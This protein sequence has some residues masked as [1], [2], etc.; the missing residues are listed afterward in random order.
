M[1]IIVKTGYLSHKGKMYGP[2]EVATVEEKDIVNELLKS[3]AFEEYKVEDVVEDTEEDTEETVDDTE[4]A[5]D[6][7]EEAVADTEET[8]LPPVEVKKTVS[9]KAKGK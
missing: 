5:V 9:R 7:T 6:D 2:G 1:E 4:E 8:E 3:E